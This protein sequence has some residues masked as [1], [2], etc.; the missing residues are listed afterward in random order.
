VSGALLFAAALA[1]AAPALAQADLFAPI[2][3][4]LQH[5]RCTNCHVAGDFVRQ[6]E[7]GRRHVP[8]VVRGPDNKG[9]GFQRCAN[10]HG[11]TNH[12]TTGA[13]GAP[14]WQFAPPSTSLDG[15]APGDACRALKDPAKN[16]KRTVGA[17]VE[18][19]RH[20]PLVLWAWAP[21]RARSV[22]PLGHAEFVAALE[23]WAKAGAPCPP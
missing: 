13:P 1:P 12:P 18:H 3:R 16:G 6:G 20:D 10:C 21:G 23:A 5:A 2:A 8:N 11:A 17:L 4:V 7:Q 22:P 9:V 19:M 14:N 15:L